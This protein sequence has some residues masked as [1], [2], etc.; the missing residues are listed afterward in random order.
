MES[1]R[2]FETSVYFIQ[3][4]R[5]YIPQSYYYIHTRR[6]ENLKSHEEFCA[7]FAVRTDLLIIISMSFGF[8]E[9]TTWLPW[10]PWNTS[11]PNPTV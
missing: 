9:N 8:G 5:R 6:R 2:T 10:L 1:V 7:L 4:I 3:T 11:S